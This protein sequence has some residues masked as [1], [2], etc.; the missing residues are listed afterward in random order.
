MSNN[1]NTDS[2]TPETTD[3]V[4]I[5]GGQAGLALGYF[6]ARQ[7]RDFV[8]LDANGRVGDAWRKRWDSLR[9]FT[10]AKFNGL[11]GMKFPGDRLSFPS[12]DEQAAYLES[13]AQRFNL[14]VLTNTRVDRLERSGAG[15]LVTAGDRQWS[16]A[17]VVVATGG[18]ERAK[19]PAF[20]K[21][22]SPR[23]RQLH[24]TEYRSPAQLQDGP[25]LVV[26]A[27]NSGA[28]IALE[29][30]RSHPTLLSGRP[31]A[32]IP[33]K[34]G[35]NAA[36]FALP[37]V[38]F[39][40]LHIL[41]LDTPMGRKAAPGFMA[42]AAPLIRTKIKDL[43]AVGVEVLPRIK[44]VQNGLPVTAEDQ[45]LDVANVI[46][47]TGYRHDFSWLDIP[48]VLDASGMPLQRRGVVE[49]APGL[50]FLGLEFLYCAASSAL[51]G[52]GRD[53]RYLAEQMASRK[54]VP[55]AARQDVV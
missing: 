16:A 38:R 9:L 33:F 27:G 2:R 44:G 14:P 29:V 10:P 23:I 45:E 4:I 42:H 47:C 37:L 17:N 15:Y 1:G 36:R 19:T 54:P 6:L 12:K 34:H 5:G 48:D 52:I 55:S 7:H 39:A 53:A 46:W 40:G 11:E 43:I 25:V 20:A 28:E 35:R 8:I 50:Y 31:S 26:G 30:V 13:Y 3:T 24:S 18:E 22:L 49:S 41:T 32:E 51:P 21:D